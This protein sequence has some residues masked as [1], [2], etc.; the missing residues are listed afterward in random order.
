[1]ARPSGESL[2]ELFS[3]LADWNSCLADIPEEILTGPNMP[4]LK[5]PEP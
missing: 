3:T 1:M 5:P 4:V 2:N